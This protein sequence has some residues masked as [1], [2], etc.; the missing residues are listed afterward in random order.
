M[1]KTSALAIV[2]A[3]ASLVA[4]PV[5]AQSSQASSEAS[6]QASSEVSLPSSEVSSQISSEVSSQLSS[7][8]SSEPS[9]APSQASSSQGGGGLGFSLDIDVSFSFQLTFEQAVEF[10]RLVVE[11]NSAPVAVDSGIDISV[12]AS[13]PSTITLTQLPVTIIALYPQFEGFLFFMLPDGRIVVVNPT[14]LKIVMI[15]AV[16]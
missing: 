3:A 6:S 10:K 14:T 4:L 8:L 11:T 5:L 2:A 13:V 9:S 15:L 16:D 12:G 7:A 1:K